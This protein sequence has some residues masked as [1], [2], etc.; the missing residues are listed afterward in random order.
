MNLVAKTDKGYIKGDIH[1]GIE[2]VD[3]ENARQFTE[4]EATTYRDSIVAD[5]F[6][7]YDCKEFCF[8]EA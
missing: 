5:M 2:F 7:F 8:E 3:K 6:D 4:R 1:V